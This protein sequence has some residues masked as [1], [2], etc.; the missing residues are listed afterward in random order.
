MRYEKV[1]NATAGLRSAVPW[2]LTS[3]EK[4]LALERQE[5]CWWR[6]AGS[7]QILKG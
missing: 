7:T 6:E 2:G 5:K 3:L 1:Q 4:G